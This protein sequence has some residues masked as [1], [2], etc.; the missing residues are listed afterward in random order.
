MRDLTTLQRRSLAILEEAR[1]ENFCTVIN[2]LI[3]KRG[4]EHEV[5][6]LKTAMTDLL[7]GGFI[8]IE[9]IQ[10][11][12]P[13]NTELVTKEKAIQLLKNVRFTIA[14]NSEKE[15]WHRIAYPQLEVCLT[16][17]G[18]KLAAQ[19]LSEDG[20]PARPLESYELNS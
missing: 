2:T 6:A 12:V 18:I 20:Y 7:N 15:H 3:K 10:T 1:S 5:E 8:E 17:A 19:I 9:T 13:S 16:E 4:K 14:W 11:D